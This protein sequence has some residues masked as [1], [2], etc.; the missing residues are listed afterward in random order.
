V[1]ERLKADLPA[2]PDAYVFPSRKGTVLPLG[3]YRWAFDNAL[4]PLQTS[5]AEKRKQEPKGE[6]TTLVF[7]YVTPHDL[8]HTCASLAISAGANVKVVQRMLGHA[9]ATM[10]LDLYGHLLSDDLAAVADALGKAMEAA[11]V[12]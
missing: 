1:W 4:K 3:E 6:E 5:A 12:P 2:D 10:T 11:L 7:P 8:R 9:T